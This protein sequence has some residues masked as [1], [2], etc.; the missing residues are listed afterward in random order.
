MGAI[1]GTNPVFSIIRIRRIYTMKNKLFVCLFSILFLF[2]GSVRVSAEV[3]ELKNGEI[4]EG[5]ITEKTDEFI[6]IET[7]SGTS[8]IK[9]DEIKE[10]REGGVDI[11]TGTI[12]E[13]TGSVEVRPEGEEKWAPIQKDTVLNE[14]DTIRTG[15][16][17]KMI[18]VL[19]KQLIIAVEPESDLELDTLQ[20]SEKEDMNVKVN[21]SKGQIWNDVG[22]LRSKDANFYVTTPQ[23]VTGVRGTIFT[24]QAGLDEK[25][26]VA[27]VDGGVKVRTRD[28]MIEPVEVK[29]NYMTEV[30]PNKPP[31]APVKISGAF[32]AQWAVY[33]AKFGALRGGLG[34]Q[35]FRPSPTQTA[36][37][38]GA[39]VGV[40]IAAAAVGKDGG[41][42][43]P[44]T[45]TV[46]ASQSG[47][48]SPI[49]ID[50]DIDG[51]SAIGSNT[52]TGVDVNV[53]CDPLTIADQF[54]IIYM[55]N[56]IGD[57]GVVAVPTQDVLLTGSA[58]GSSPIVT[59][60][61]ITGPLGTDW[62]WDAEVV[63]NLE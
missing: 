14:G 18:T 47:N 38:V 50:T 57:T 25:T 39:G 56:V 45:V 46:T 7:V 12:E 17:S 59:I 27:V 60:R 52:V 42:S 23:A 32:L 26:T 5:E 54:Q 24:V 9:P 28:M 34:A 19:G 44:N 16:D 31:A 4:I 2:C 22:K 48:Y 29:E 37:G 21:L 33:Q 49:P 8:F 63:F 13:V 1:K 11:S 30:V 55:G 35:G 43:G 41:S 61:V 36:A 20:K 10:I 6:A 53:L 51:S 40:G 62:H 3:I 58:S 15:P